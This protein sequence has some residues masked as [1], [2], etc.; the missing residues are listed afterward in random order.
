M[1]GQ[2]VEVLNTDAEGRLVLSDCLTYTQEN[3]DPECII[4]L[5]TLTGA[6]LVALGNTYAGCFANDD[7][8]ADD[9]L[10]SSRKTNEKLWRLP[11]DEEFDAMLKSPVADMANIGGER[12]MAGS[13]TAAHFLKR[14]IKDGVKW[15]HLDIAGMAWD[16]KGKNPICPRGAV[17]FGVRLLN[18]YIQDNHESK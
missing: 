1:S 2:T 10:K 17:G 16:K 8:L 5:A 3:F 4:D 11:L 7:E 13:S 6:V 9:L 18:Q 12:G 15:A 14:F